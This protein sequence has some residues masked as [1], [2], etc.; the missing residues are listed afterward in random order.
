M[1]KVKKLSGYT[2]SLINEPYASA[3]PDNTESTDT[4][5]RY[6][7]LIAQEVEE[8]LPEV[9]LQYTPESSANSKYLSIAYGNMMG[10][11]VEAIKELSTQISEIKE[12][13]RIK[14]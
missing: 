5:R 7:G 9:I 14:N 4:A 12:E 13:L 10:I 3:N 8:V 2:Y 6:T 1:E 11:I